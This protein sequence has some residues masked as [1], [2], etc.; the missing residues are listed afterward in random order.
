VT[1]SPPFCPHRFVKA[2]NGEAAKTIAEGKNFVGSSSSINQIWR[3]EFLETR[4]VRNKVFILKKEGSIPHESMTF[5]AQENHTK[6]FRVW[7]FRR[8]RV[9]R[10]W[11]SRR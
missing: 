3:P 2:R 7:H 5:K 8:Q 11:S 1:A 6:G 9:F 10:V 4:I